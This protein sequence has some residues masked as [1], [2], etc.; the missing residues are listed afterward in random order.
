[1][2]YICEMSDCIVGLRLNVMALILLFYIFFSF[3]SLYC[4]LTLKICVRVFSGT[5][6]VRILKH[7]IHTNNELLYCGVENRTRCSYS[8]LY[9]SIFLSSKARFAPRFSVE[10][11]K[12]KSSIVECIK[13]LIALAT[14]LPVKVG[15]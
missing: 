3:L 9:L 11:F 4:M 1:M 15:P 5:I 14:S 8:C 12:L 6:V 7:G 10:L 2:V 13:S